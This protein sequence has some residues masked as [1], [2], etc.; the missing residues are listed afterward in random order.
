[1]NVKCQTQNCFRPNYGNFTLVGLPAYLQRQLQSVTDALA[2]LHWLRVPQRVDY[3]VAV[4]VFRALNGLSTPYL[5]QLVRVADQPGR[6]CLRSSSSHRQQVPTYRLA[7]VGRRSFPVSA[8][9]LWNSLSAAIPS[10]SSL[11]DFCQ[12]S[13]DLPTSCFNYSYNDFASVILCNDTC[14][15][16]TL[17]ILILLIPLNLLAVAKHSRY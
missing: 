3:K 8:S 6:H 17:K 5:D 4:M 7:T 11:T 14:Y 15:L 1:M 10:S 13:T 9:I 2:V 16:V 12:S